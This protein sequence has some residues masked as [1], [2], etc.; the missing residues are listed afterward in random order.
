[1]SFSKIDSLSS[2]KSI[3]GSWAVSPMARTKKAAICPRVTLRLG[4]KDV[5]SLLHP[6]VTPSAASASMSDSKMFPSSS[7]KLPPG[8]TVMA[9]PAAGPAAARPTSR[10]STTTTIRKRLISCLPASG[11]PMRCPSNEVTQQG[12]RE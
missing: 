1:M 4:Q 10:I 3:A 5:C 8:G 9:A 2:V 11:D 7:K 12:W 6:L